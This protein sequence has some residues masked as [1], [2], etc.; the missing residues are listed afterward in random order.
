MQHVQPRRRSGGGYRVSVSGALESTAALAVVEELGGGSRFRT[1]ERYVVTVA[2]SSVC[3]LPPSLTLFCFN[4]ISYLGLVFLGITL[5][6][7]RDL[8][9]R[10][11]A[12][13][14]VERRLAPSSISVEVEPDVEVDFALR[15]VLATKSLAT[16][17]L[18]PG[19]DVEEEDDDEHGYPAERQVDVETPPAGDVGRKGTAQER[20]RDGRGAKGRAEE[21]LE[22]GPSVQRHRVDQH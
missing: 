8:L 15:G 22:H 4:P 19:R 6:C 14:L 10:T 12:G 16:S 17:C 2:D 5:I 11:L 18:L 1:A 9:G 20:P 3:A 13:V 21:A 7:K